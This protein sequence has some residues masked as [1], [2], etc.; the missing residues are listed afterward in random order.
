MYNGTKNPKNSRK[1]FK[2]ILA[3]YPGTKSPFLGQKKFSN[4]FWLQLVPG[5]TIQKIFFKA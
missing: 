1:K 3:I 5:T 4:S 2:K